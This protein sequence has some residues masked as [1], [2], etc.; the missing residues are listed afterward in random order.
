[1][2]THT[3]LAVPTIERVDTIEIEP[4]II[5]GAQRFGQ[6]VERA[7]TDPRSRIIV[8]DAKS[9]FARS[10]EKYDLI[11]SEP[12]NPWVA[13]VA[14][15]F[16]EEFYRRLRDY[17]ADDGLL[18]QWVHAYEFEDPLLGSITSALA[19]S[20]PAY[21]VYG[22]NTGDLLLIAPKSGKLG[23]ASERLFGIEPLARELRH[24]G[25]ES[26]ADLE[27]RR[28]AGSSLT[29]QALHRMKF[30]PNSDYFPLVEL[31][32]PEARFRN[33]TAR[34]LASL[35][36]APIPLVELLEHDSIPDY[37][38][39]S[40]ARRDI[41]PRIDAALD[42]QAA[43]DLLVVA[44][45]GKDEPIPPRHPY[46]QSI[47]ITR[48]LLTDCVHL[49]NTA[50]AWDHVLTIAMLVNP[51]LPA[52]RADPLWKTMGESACLQKMPPAYRMWLRLFRSVANRDATAIARD[53][54]ALI[55][56]REKTS[57]QIEYLV[58]AASTGYLATGNV[59]DARRI[60]KSA[61]SVMPLPI[62]QLPWFVLLGDLAGL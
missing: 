46:A 14:P 4:A 33:V 55:A 9:F 56:E 23:K 8:D 36:A 15:L 59:A 51:Y 12:S 49:G 29:K 57:A 35:A 19:K 6:R 61:F 41:S 39:V 1:M 30:T 13:G 11:V 26:L 21:S 43:V 42:A 2:T 7:Y 50:V 45:H 25:I 10:R 27:M 38:R 53:A 5:E 60:L 17:L 62:Q 34:T 22:T 47:A 52:A 3:L 54:E 40:A 28:L 20:F 16:T 32:A 37:G 48:M 18:V 31:Q 58:L 24:L 44:A